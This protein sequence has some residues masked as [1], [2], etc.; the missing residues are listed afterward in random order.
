MYEMNFCF[1][2]LLLVL[3][4]ADSRKYLIRNTHRFK[5]IVDIHMSYCSFK[6]NLQPTYPKD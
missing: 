6:Y 2:V 4:N 1:V 5:K 3:L